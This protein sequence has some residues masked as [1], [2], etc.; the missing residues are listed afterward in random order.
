MNNID[1]V[2]EL[3]EAE[4]VRVTERHKSYDPD[5]G[6]HKKFRTVEIDAEEYI[7]EMIRFSTEKSVEVQTAYENRDSA[8][9]WA[10]EILG[11]LGFTLVNVGRYGVYHERPKGVHAP[12]MSVMLN[13]GSGSL[14]GYGHNANRE[15]NF[16]VSTDK[17]QR[18]YAIKNGFAKQI[19]RRIEEQDRIEAHF[20][21]LKSGA[22]L[23]Q[24]QVKVAFKNAIRGSQVGQSEAS[25]NSE[26]VNDRH[27]Y[28]I[29]FAGR[30]VG[31]HYV[32]N[33]YNKAFDKGSLVVELDFFAGGPRIRKTMLLEDF[34]E[35]SLI[36]LIYLDGVLNQ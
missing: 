24:T 8:I 3:V 19:A 31:L 4:L 16:H 27:V 11:Q 17:T 26:I 28:S 10:E 5:N 15:P 35:S 7:A 25:L 14:H 20:A 12:K 1:R 2:T 6:R 33:D 30:N 29:E 13:Y 34:V 22:Y 23:E 21:E 9:S 32:S 36:H 18:H